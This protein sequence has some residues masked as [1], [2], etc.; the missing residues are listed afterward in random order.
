ME[1]SESSLDIFAEEQDGCVQ[2]K[3]LEVSVAIQQQIVKEALEIVFWQGSRL[4]CCF[5]SSEI[6]FF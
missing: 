3:D 1:V 6:T 4:M 5:I 2:I